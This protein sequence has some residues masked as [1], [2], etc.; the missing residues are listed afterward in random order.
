MLWSERLWLLQVGNDGLYLERYTHGLGTPLL[1]DSPKHLWHGC[2]GQVKPLRMST[3]LNLVGS[4]ARNGR[5]VLV[6]DQ[7]ERETACS[8][9]RCTMAESGM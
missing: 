2:K 5:A 4:L 9:D 3:R 7:R 1:P 8:K 6:R